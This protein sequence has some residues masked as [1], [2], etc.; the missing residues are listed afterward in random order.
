MSVSALN[1]T[2]ANGLFFLGSL[3]RGILKIVLDTTPADHG[4]SH[5]TVQ[6]ILTNKHATHK[7]LQHSSSTLESERTHPPHAMASHCICSN[8]R[9]RIN[10]QNISLPAVLLRSIRLDSTTRSTTSS[11]N[12]FPRTDLWRRSAVRLVLASRACQLSSRM[13]HTRELRYQ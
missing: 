5:Q 13:R 8:Q 4:T 12:R 3:Q 11:N 7:H 10:T 1:V 6:P 9:Q 2:T